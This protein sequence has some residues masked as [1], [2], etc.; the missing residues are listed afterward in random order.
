MT[1]ATAPAAINDTAITMTATTATDDSGVK[2]YFEC[3]TNGDF[4]S[5][6]QDSSDYT[7]TGLSADTSYTFRVKARDK[8]SNLNETDWS[9]IASATTDDAPPVVP[10]A[11]WSM[12]E[13]S[14]SIAGD[15]AGTNDGTVHGALWTSSGAIDGGL[16]FDG[17]GDYVDCGNG[18]SLDLTGS[19]TLSAWINPDSLSGTIISK[20][21]YRDAQYLFDFDNGA[22]RFCWYN[23]GWKVVSYDASG[24]TSQW[25]HVAV[26]YDSV[27]DAVVLYLDGSA[28]ASDTQSPGLLRNSIPVCIGAWVAGGNAKNAFD[29]KVDQV[30]IFDSALSAGDVL[31]LYNE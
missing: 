6:W 28:V 8:S 7:A 12:D 11:H 13:G 4:N 23:G 24:L 19:I 10:I 26:T 9:G 20:R 2:Y 14:G 27:T 5:L 29:G 22:L 31:T 1:W 30:K 25:S 21:Q 3:T 15:S 17:D 16:S 18:S